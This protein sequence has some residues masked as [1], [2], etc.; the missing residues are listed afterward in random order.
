MRQATEPTEFSATL[1]TDAGNGLASKQLPPRRVVLLGAS[2]LTR[3]ISTVVETAQNI[4]GQPLE[5]L[6]A[7]GH[8][9]SYG[10][11]SNFLG[12]LLPG[13]VQCGVWDALSARPDVPTAAL[14]TDIGNDILYE[15][16]VERILSW[17]ETSVDRLQAVGARICITLPPLDSAHGLSESRFQFFR[18]LFFPKCHLELPEVVERANQLH[19]GLVRLGASKG[20][21]VIGQRGDWYGADP[22]HIC[23]RHWRQAWLE[24][25]TPWHDGPGNGL[26]PARGSLLRWLF[27][28]TRAPHRR[29]FFGVEMC[30]KQPAARMRNGTVLSFY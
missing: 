7:L 2:N 23:L 19:D 22:I 27:L 4:W 17:V 29:K 13:I 6:G 28:R 20:V 10:I 5:V 21:A 1:P 16:P 12:R 26:I 3:G 25:L 11:D 8:G 15:V 30:A 14:I 24:I 9:R 18:H